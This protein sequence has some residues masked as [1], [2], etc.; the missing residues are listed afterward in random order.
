MVKDSKIYIAGHNGMVGSAILRKLK[1]EGYE[2]IIFK[3][4][5]ELDLRIQ[6]NVDE[7]LS[8][9][10]P[11]YIIDAAAIV[12]G[13]WA[14][15][16]Y[17]YRFLMDNM[18]IQNNLINASINNKIKNF[19]FLGSSCIYPKLATQP[20]KEEYLLSGPLE[21]TNKWYAIAKITGVK[22]IESI[23]NEF[24]YN[25][26]SLMPTNLYGPNDNFDEM[27]SHVIPGMIAKFHKA[28]IKNIKSV[29]LWGDGSPLREF[30]HVDDLAEA[31]NL[32]LN[33]EA[34]D[35]IYNVGSDQEISIKNLAKLV[36]KTVRYN[37]EILWDKNFPNG[38]PKKKL[39][40][41]KIHEFGFSP[42]IKL[43]KDGL[44]TVYNWYINSQI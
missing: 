1:N 6:K 29:T 20:M 32:F 41:R 12:G 23:R 27:T 30:L 38:T 18:L 9:E 34:K 19:I 44:K 4:S 24:G 37:G 16:E 22:L 2:N 3:S 42:K 15:N 11:E 8:S 39:D 10:K 5:K 14:N 35:F 28:K 17:Q 26:V 33:N 7:F 25:Y 13:I 40:S 21:E 43:E 36:S 31:I